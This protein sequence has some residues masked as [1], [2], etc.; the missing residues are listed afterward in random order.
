MS[1]INYTFNILITGKEYVGKTSL[2]NRYS[3]KEHLNYTFNPNNFNTNIYNERFNDYI[4]YLDNYYIKLN[5]IDHYSFNDIAFYFNI[6]DIILIICDITDDN[7]YNIEH[8]LKYKKLYCDRKIDHYI[9]NNKVD[10]INILNEK[11]EYTSKYNNISCK[12][13][14]GINNLFKMI[15]R[16]LID[17][18]KQS[19]NENKIHYS[20]IE[21]IISDSESNN[22]SNFFNKLFKF[23]C[24]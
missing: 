12:T 22:K 17:D 20:K 21:Y 1:N 14:Y 18:K 7:S 4:T 19:I 23:C 24:K 6:A 10:L 5:I 13:G 9:V 15:I 3:N 8:I 11:I 16:R 2:I